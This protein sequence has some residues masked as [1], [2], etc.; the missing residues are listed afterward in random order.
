VTVT[1]YFVRHGSH[2]YLGKVLCGRDEQVRLNSVGL[3]EAEAL[4]S[5]LCGEGLDAVYASPL[6]R[7]RET[8]APIAAACGLDYKI[9]EGLIELDFGAWSGRPFAALAGDPDWDRWN[10]ARDA[11]RPPGGETMQEVQARVADFLARAQAG[12]AGGRVA[13]VAHGD[14]IK[15]AMSYALGLPINHLHRLEISPA[16]VS[17][18]VAGAWGMKVHSIN[19]V[20]R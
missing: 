8:A 17:V 18:L 14:V 2:D 9:D 4:A 13:A 15:A 6:A 12:H 5:R 10:D 11:A 7:T 19:E 20:P 3:G 1:V 16:S